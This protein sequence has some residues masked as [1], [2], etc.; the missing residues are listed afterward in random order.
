VKDYLNINEAAKETGLSI[1]TIRAKLSRGMLPNAHQVQEG[2]RQLWRIPFNDLIAA[3]LIDK[4]RPGAEA[5]AD[6]HTEALKRE[7]DSLTKELEATRELLKLTTQTLE[8]YRERERR[9]FHSLETRET[10]EKRR[11]LWERLRG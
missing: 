10:Q 1:P 11:S 2:K 8:D 4:V 7:L 3:G 9:L 6:T 5:L